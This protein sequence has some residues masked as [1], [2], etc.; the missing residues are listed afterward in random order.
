MNKPDIKLFVVCHKP[1][2]VP[3]NRLLCP[4][5]VGASLAANRLSDMYHDDEGDNISEKNKS[6]CE[7]T[8][9]YWAWKNVQADYYGFFH[10]RR[11]LSFDPA[12]H[13]EDEWGNLQF[14][15]ITDAAIKQLK[16]NEEDMTD[17]ISQYD[18]IVTRG[19]KIALGTALKGGTTVYKEYGVAPFQ[20]REDFDK[21]LEILYRKYPEYKPIAEEY[22][23]GNTAHECNMFIMSRELFYEYCEWIFD[24]LFETEKV[25]DTTHYSVEE[26]RIYG[27]LA[28]RLTGIFYRYV[29]SRGD[30]KTLEVA[31]SMF[32]DTEPKQVLEPVYEKAVPIVLSA[33]DAFSPYLDVM[34]RSIVANS[35][36]EN[37]YDL[38]V[39]YSNISERNQKLIK[40]AAKGRD[41]ISIR[42][43]KVSDYFDVSKLFVDQHLSV[44]TYFRLI[45]PELMPGY[46]KILYL[47]CDM[48]VDDDVAKLYQ[49]DI[50]NA[51]IGAAKD[52]DVAGQINLKQ[53]K[54]DEYAVEKLGL[55]S[56]YDYFQAG[57]LILNLDEIR[58]V[59]TSDQLI[60][61]ATENDFRC[62]DQDVLNVVCKNRVYYIPQEWNT[63]MSWAEPGRSRMDILKY[64]PRDL[65]GEYSAARNNPRII[66]FAGY[67]KPW[68][69]GDCD[70]ATYFWKY[71]RLSPYYEMLIR[72]I[73]LF[74]FDRDREAE[75]GHQQPQPKVSAR[76]KFELWLLPYGSKRREGVKKIFHLFR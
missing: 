15:S 55:E 50:G 65:F 58:K 70:M 56:P 46:G 12:D 51:L 53:N 57:V 47:D 6:Y 31:K 29:L 9:H 21:M 45:I 18:M 52:I 8:A 54:W 61:I 14:E 49:L 22:L 40:E 67:Q 36:G 69:M 59:T 30:K 73:W 20:H 75:R 62:H 74:Q 37:N 43:A 71:A 41:N 42:F 39:L 1:S 72:Q 3:E 64:A 11:Y 17:L 32:V 68:Q 2:Y 35:N 44:E 13:S 48:V 26:Y 27:Y 19:R 28:E 63:L 10:Y 33:N 24:I 60:K 34:I 4:I 38:I 66:H 7:L 16:L 5:Q 76:K 23:A 25:I